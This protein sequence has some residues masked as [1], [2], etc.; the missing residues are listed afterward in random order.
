MPIDKRQK[1][2]FVKWEPAKVSDDTAVQAWVYLAHAYHRIVRRLEQV[3]DEHD[4]TLAQFEVLA[5]LHFD[6]AISQNELAQRLLV[7]KGNIC[8]LIDRLTAAKLVTRKTDPDDRR[9][10]QLHMTTLG[11]QKFAASFPRHIELIQELM[12]EVP[13][14]NLLVLKNHLA[15]LSRI[16][17]V[18][19]LPGRANRPHHTKCKS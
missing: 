6:G 5:R 16:E 7:T 12:G 17:D 14:E 4:L 15:T 3:L 8:G 13:E 9:A 1:T 18:V 10:N 11:R 2:G 19:D